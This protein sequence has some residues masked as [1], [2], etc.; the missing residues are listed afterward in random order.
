[1]TG[2]SSSRAG[3]ALLWAA[4][5]AAA[6]GLLLAL[7][8]R[9]AVAGLRWVALFAVGIMS[10]IVFVRRVVLARAGAGGD[11]G[12]IQIALAHLAWGLVALA[13]ILRQSSAAGLIAVA[14]VFAV[15][16]ALS[17]S[18]RL[19]VLMQPREPART[20]GDMVGVATVGVIAAAI[21][22][23]AMAALHAVRPQ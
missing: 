6:A 13:M 3:N 9:S 4:Y 20:T 23:F 22:W 16:L 15:Y 17:A 10:L 1:M 11:D 18:W 12:H 8:E 19:I 21:A 14:L 7:N 2:E 5:V